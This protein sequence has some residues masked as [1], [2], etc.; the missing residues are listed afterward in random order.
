VQPAVRFEPTQSDLELE[1]VSRYYSAI[2]RIQTLLRQ[3][4]RNQ[5]ASTASKLL[6]PGRPLTEISAEVAAFVQHVEATLR[7]MTAST[8][9]MR[10]ITRDLEAG[11]RY[12]TDAVDPWLRYLRSQGEVSFDDRAR[13]FLNSDMLVQHFDAFRDGVVA[14]D[15][16][17]LLRSGPEGGVESAAGFDDDATPELRTLIVV[18]ASLLMQ[19]R[20]ELERK[21]KAERGLQVFIYHG[22][23]QAVPSPEVLQHYDFVL[24]TYSVLHLGLEGGAYRPPSGGGGGSFRLPRGA[25]GGGARAFGGAKRRRAGADD[26]AGVFAGGGPGGDAGLGSSLP[27]D[28]EV[29]F[30]RTRASPLFRV[31]WKRLILDEAHV[32]RNPSSVWWRA[33][34]RVRATKRWAVTATPLHNTVGDLQTLLAVTGLPRLPISNRNESMLM[35][36]PTLQRGIARALRPCFLR[37]NPTVR[38]EDGS[39]TQLVVLPPKTDQVRLAQLTSDEVTLYNSSLRVFQSKVGALSANGDRH[40]SSAMHAFAMMTKLRQACCHPWLIEGRSASEIAVTCG[41]CQDE[42]VRPVYA[43][44]GHTFCFT[45]LTNRFAEAAADAPP[46]DEVNAADAGDGG[47][48]EPQVADAAGPV[49]SP[50]GAPRLAQRVPCPCCGTRIQRRVLFAGRGESNALAHPKRHRAEI[51]AEYLQRPW[52]SSSKLEMLL[53][54]LRRIMATTDDKV[55]VFSQFTSFLDVIGIAIERAEM[56]SIRIDGSLDLKTRDRLIEAF[57]ES[58]EIRVLLASKMAMG[59][60]LNLVAANHVIVVDPWWNPAVEE[61]AVH[62]VYRIGQTKPVFVQRFVMGDTIEQY[63]YNVS[64]KK[65]EFSDSVMGAASSRVS[66][67]AAAAAAAAVG[68]TAGTTLVEYG[69]RI[70]PSPQAAASDATTSAAVMQEAAALSQMEQQGDAPAAMQNRVTRFLQALPEIRVDKK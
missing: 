18:P 64:C 68:A 38:E 30:D 9:D 58:G 27:S 40:R 63:C 24:T 51:V 14:A 22:L 42:C 70:A 2:Y 36:D 6:Q 47:E 3:L 35:R 11:I 62:R 19:W 26:S 32:V 10:A 45:C 15:S 29:G 53:D 54:A 17:G 20:A 65:K 52:T 31:H 28:V 37:R 61:Q 21:V 48:G 25:T 41:I 49:L 7:T 1:L 5:V 34:S 8:M 33:V 39:V 43:Q 69:D 50:T 4:E 67:A 23:G 59:V 60:G 13:A 57:T 56:R 12:F 66:R 55:V 44:C 16:P 46:E